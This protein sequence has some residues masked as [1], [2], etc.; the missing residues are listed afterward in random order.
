LSGELE[1]S[2]RFEAETPLAACRANGTMVATA[3]SCAGGTIATST[4]IAG[5]S[6]VVDH[7][8]VIYTD[9]ATNEMIGV[10]MSLIQ[11]HRA[12]SE[13]VARRMAREAQAR[14]HA[15]AAFLS[16]GSLAQTVA[17]PKNRWT[18]CTSDCH[19]SGR[20]VISERRIFARDHASVRAFTV[21]HAFSIIK[22]YLMVR[23]RFESV[24]TM[25]PAHAESRQYHVEC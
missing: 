8:F 15:T 13:E 14:S 6:H 16:P 22:A 3:E 2:R 19:G 24:A 17:Q 11:S 5:S 21:Q 10:P 1:L 4:A 20:R 18:P 25:S 23:T 9:E 12:V 7:R